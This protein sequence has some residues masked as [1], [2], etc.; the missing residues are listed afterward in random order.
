MFGSDQLALDLARQF[1]NDAERRAANHRLIQGL[2]S[3]ERS[4]NR[5]LRVVVG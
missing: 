2:S 3:D 1:R 4:G 5:L